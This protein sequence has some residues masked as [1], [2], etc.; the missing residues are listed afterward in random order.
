MNRPRSESVEAA[1]AQRLAEAA[2]HLGADIIDNAHGPVDTRDPANSPD[3]VDAPDP[4]NAADAVNAQGVDRDAA[5]LLDIVARVICTRPTPDRLWLALAAIAGCLPH[6]DD[7]NEARYRAETSNP[8]QMAMWML[9]YALERGSPE[10]D[11][12]ALRVAHDTVLVDPGISGEERTLKP[13][14]ALVASIISRW[15]TRRDVLCVS[16]TP[17]SECWTVAASGAMEIVVPWHT[18]VVAFGRLAPGACERIAGAAEFSGSQ[19]AALVDDCFPAASAFLRADA[20]VRSV[21]TYLGVLR[22]FGRLVALSKAS[23]SDLRG[24]TSALPAQGLDGPQ[25]AFCNLPTTTLSLP[26]PV[27]ETPAVAKLSP[28]NATPTV[29]CVGNPDDQS[30]QSVLISA[31]ERLRREG[32]R[33]ELTFAGTEVPNIDS[34]YASSRFT[35]FPSIHE[36]NSLAISQCLARRVPVVCS[37]FLDFAPACGIASVDTSD[38]ASLADVMRTLL[39]DDDAVDDLLTQIDRRREIS[40]GDFAEDLW[41]LLVGGHGPSEDSTWSGRGA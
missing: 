11:T 24:F 28:S 22:R 27:P 30:D 7:V 6:A 5:A 25:V 41:G 31:C 38:D 1:L 2:P 29:L 40:Y 10:T 20:T 32:L 23:A 15:A 12:R 3:P 4:A 14:D 8:A 18:T 9:D 34:L 16:W 33:F 17:G 21:A 19:F 35:V 37:K 13:F 26:S 39:V 36:G